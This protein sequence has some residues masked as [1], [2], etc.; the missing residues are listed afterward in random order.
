M[1]PCAQTSTS[2][3]TLTR[4]FTDVSGMDA[5]LLSEARHLLDQARMIAE[6]PAQQVSEVGH[7]HP[8]SQSPSGAWTFSTSTLQACGQQI[9]QAIAHDS[10]AELAAANRWAEREIETL[11]HSPAG[12]A[13][14]PGEFRA[15]VCAQHEGMLAGVVA[16]L[17]MTS[18]TTVRK[19][20]AEDGRE[21][22]TGHKLA[23][24]GEG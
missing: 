19:M 24:M 21:P 18:V 5:K 14:T 1:G 4:G 20:R 2:S 13:E 7:G 22:R 6:A 16:R 10:D 9:N 15:R 3:P 8:H 17:E 23:T 11:Q 12:G